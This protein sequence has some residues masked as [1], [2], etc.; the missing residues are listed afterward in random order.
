MPST[1][2]QASAFIVA[3][4]VLYSYAVWGE[5]LTGRLSR[6]FI[7]GFWLGLI[8]DGTGTLLMTGISSNSGLPALIHFGVGAVAILLMGLHTAWAALVWCRADRGSTR[9]FH[10]YSRYVY[11]LW[12]VAV[13]SGAV[14][15]MRG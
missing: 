4:L 10:H 2:M 11:V 7:A 12:L 15:G 13:V 1:L 5:Q 8:C 14:L 6:P 9:L 3:A